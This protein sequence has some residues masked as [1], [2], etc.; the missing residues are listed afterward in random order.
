MV[1][2]RTYVI[3]LLSL[4]RTDVV[5]VPCVFVYKKRN[6]LCWHAG[7]FWNLHELQSVTTL[8]NLTHGRLVPTPA[9]NTITLL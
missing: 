6:L 2:T 8:T 7:R 3:S 4:R 1:L 5:P 9:Y